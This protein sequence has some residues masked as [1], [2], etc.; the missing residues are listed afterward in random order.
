MN[1]TIIDEDTMRA[2][3]RAAEELREH[4]RTSD[5]Y[6]GGEGIYL[7]DE[8]GDSVPERSWE[9]V[10]GKHP[11]HW[12]KIWQVA[13]DVEVVG[14]SVREVMRIWDDPDWTPDV[15]FYTEAVGD[16]R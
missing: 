14:M 9:E 12:R 16:C 1:E 2:I 4:V 7:I 3:E 6:K 15:R 13:G 5:E 10:W 8:G 11:E